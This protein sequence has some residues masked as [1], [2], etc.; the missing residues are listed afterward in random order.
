MK[1]II[2][3]FTFIS[4]TLLNY[5]QLNNADFE[6]WENPLLTNSFNV[7]GNVAGLTVYVCAST[8]SYNELENWSSTNQLTNTPAF[9]SEELVTESSIAYSGTKSVRITSKDLSITGYLAPGC[10]ALPQTIDNVAPGLIVNGSFKLD[11]QVLVDELLGGAGLNAL[12]PF[13]YTGVGEAIDF[14]PKSI[15]GYYNYTGAVDAGTGQID[16]FI[17]VS[18]L[19]K[20]GEIIGYCSERFASTTSFTQFSIDYTHLNCETPDTIVTVISASSLDFEIVDGEFVMNTSFT[21]VD[22]SILFIDDLHIDTILPSEFPPLLLNEDTVIL[23]NTTA[24]ISVLS[25]DT[26]CDGIIIAP[27]HFYT[28]M[29]GVATVTAGNELEFVPN[30]DFLGT[31]TIPYYA[32]NSVPLCD[33]AYLTITYEPLDICYAN[34]DNYSLVQGQVS[35]NDPNLNDVDCGT[36]VT[37]ITNTVNGV[38]DLNFNGTINYSPDNGFVGTD[39]L[40]YSIC[41][42]LVTTQCDTASIYYSIVSGINEIGENL[43]QFYPNP[44]KNTLNILV[45]V[46]KLIHVN[47]INTLGERVLSSTFNNSTIVDLSSL[48]NGIYFVEI[49]TDG[50]KSIRKLQVIK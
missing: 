4:L 27:T 15:S 36:F 34:N 43:I 38:A 32:C 11:P 42:D 22:G 49:E 16:S 23:V 21:G 44:A 8:F 24:T 47:I 20:N 35:T 48:N 2:T 10:V 14:I 37:I 39:S 18:G 26:Y 3:L 5:A 17:V 40:T 12:N 46:N 33:T 25:N 28:G 1:K 30:T 45:D 9:G 31:V 19:K 29:N 6:T 13:T 41:N 50:K 7:T